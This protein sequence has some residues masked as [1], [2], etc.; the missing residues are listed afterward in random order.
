MSSIPLTPTVGSLIIHFSSELWWVV[1]FVRD[2]FSHF[3]KSFYLQASPPHRKIPLGGLA[4]AYHSQWGSPRT[5]DWTLVLQ[6]LKR[7]N[8]GWTCFPP[9]KRGVSVNFFFPTLGRKT[10]GSFSHQAVRR[11]LIL[12]PL[13]YLWEAELSNLLCLGRTPQT[14]SDDLH[15]AQW[16][17]ET[18]L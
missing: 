1:A 4:G 12:F 3:P 11:N 18:E 16:V 13:P 17:W 8:S 14:T 2:Q 7:K 9:R 15:Y 5:L 10:P 6:E